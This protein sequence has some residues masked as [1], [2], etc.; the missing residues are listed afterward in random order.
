MNDTRCSLSISPCAIMATALVLLNVPFGD[1]R[2]AG[3]EETVETARRFL[4]CSDHQERVALSGKLAKYEGDWHDVVEALRPRSVKAVEPGY[5]RE[6]HF[7]DPQ[8]R[9]KHSD[10]LLYLLVPSNYRLDRPTG[11]VVF[12]HGGGK[13]SPR[14]APDRY[15]MP[16][17]PDTPPSSTRLGDMFE[18]LG[19]IG[20]GPSAPWNEN[21]HSRWCLPEA[22]DY[23]ADVVRECKSRFHIDA[24]RV[25]LLGHSMG[26][27]GAYHQVQ[28]QPDRFAAVIA[29]AG[30]WTLAQWPVIQGTT[31]S[32]VHG[33]K[34]ADLGVRDRHTD[35]A[36]ARLAH[37]LLSERGIPHAYKEHPE[38]HSFGY[39]KPYVVDFLKT[40]GDLRRDPFFAHV[41]LASAV[42]YSEGKCYPVRH[43]RWVTL[44]A[45]NYGPLEYDALKSQGPGHSKDSSPEEWTQWKLTHKSV[46]RKGAMVEAINLGENRLEVATRNVSRFTLWLHPAMVDFGKPIEITVNRE[47]RFEGRVAPSLATVLDSYERRR[48]WGLVYP[49][50]ITLDVNSNQE[51]AE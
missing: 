6:E 1:A 44:D 37:D 22:D 2:A 42:G 18:T 24:D 4:A 40:S 51:R 48:D 3:L 20:V 33:I 41:V 12:M 31:L 9:E 28:R 39:A 50:K 21:D 45:A 36:F 27:F 43:N 38:G 29:S 30:S 8:L 14:T 46:Q 32:I 23:I 26:G 35:I 11:L 17:A 5:Y 25:F 16:A 7:K 10:D 15:M 47:Q 13:G 19:M 34:D 49:A